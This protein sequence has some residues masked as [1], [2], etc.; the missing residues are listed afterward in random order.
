LPSF[1]PLADMSAAIDLQGLARGIAF[2]LKENS[3]A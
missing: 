1:K 2:R 3:S